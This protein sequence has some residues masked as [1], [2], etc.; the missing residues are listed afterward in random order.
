MWQ[1]AARGNI[2]QNT[3]FAPHAAL[4][5][6]C[7]YCIQQMLVVCKLFIALWSLQIYC[8]CWSVQLLYVEPL[9]KALL[10]SN[11]DPQRRLV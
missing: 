9:I 2:Q 7:N 1:W 10:K 4:S 6:E 3:T 8:E 5:G 11:Y